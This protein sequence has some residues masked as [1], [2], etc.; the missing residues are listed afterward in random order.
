MS[1]QNT[2]TSAK[3]ITV[4]FGDAVLQAGHTA[5]PNLVLKHYAELGITP[6]EMMF[7]IHVWQ[8][9]WTERQPFPSLNTIAKRM[10]I[11]RRQ[12]RKYTQSLKEKGYL[13]VHDRFSPSLGQT[14]SEYDFTPLLQAIV[15]QAQGHDDDNTT[16]TTDSLPPRNNPSG[17]GRNYRSEARRNPSSYEEDTGL[18]KT[19]KEED[20]HNSNIRMASPQGESGE[21]R[22]EPPPGSRASESVGEILER[23]PGKGN[24]PRRS[25][26]R[27]ETETEE[28]QTIQDYIID[29]AR[30][31]GDGASTKSSTT[32]A[33]NLFVASKLPVGAFLDKMYQARA[34]TQESSPKI[35][36]MHTDERGYS[37]KAKMAYFFAVLEDQLKPASGRRGA[38][39]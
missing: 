35:T 37:R 23:L 11:T 8:F 39:P 22:S 2:N 13:Q 10:D 9:W 19:Q 4:R 1:T 28:W 7:I 31:L 15:A 36:K 21:H 12:A 16:P 6:T 29:F 32:R 5:V 24:G 27:S 17:G 26:P 18:I 20:L 34:L 25:R 33:Y 3:S 30:L 14:S 38:T